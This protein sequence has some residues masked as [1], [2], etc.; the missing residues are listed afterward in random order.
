MKETD[1][2]LFASLPPTRLFFRCALPSMVSM[3]VSSLY[4][5]ADGIF[6][7]QFIGPEALAAV[8]L[9]MPIIMMGFSL[10]N[11]VAVGSSVQISI[12]LGE[13][14]RREA[15]S[16]F[17]VASLLILAISAV[18]GALGLFFAPNIL[19][20]MGADPTL[21]GL[22]AEYLRVF[23]AFSPAVMI[24]FAVDNY[25]RICGK[26][27]Y[28]MNMNIVTSVLNI[29]L[30]ALFLGV[31]RLGVGWAAFASCLS[32]TV[33]TVMGFWPFLRG[34]LALRFAKGKVPAKAIGNMLANGSS[35]FF[36]GIASSVAMVILNTALLR[37]AGSM[38]VAA[39]S[40]VMYV[41]SIVKSLLYG[42]V[43]AL[44]PAVS[45]NYGA[46]EN[47][48]VLALEGRLCLAGALISLVVLAAMQLGGGG[49][50]GLFTQSADSALLTMSVRA[51]Q[52][53]SLS[54]LV[55]WFGMLCSAFFT[56]L[57]RPVFSLT[58][59]FCQTLAFPL[60]FLN[61]LPRF[62][63]LDGIWAT[64]PASEFV[65]AILAGALLWRQLLKL[66]AA[67]KKAPTE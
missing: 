32:L 52:L 15:D 6:V 23:S 43:D 18:V 3:A 21:T 39:F 28:S 2:S 64:M 13:G 65:V 14:K 44:Q 45:Y 62:W 24:F 25:L 33:G 41:D 22:A 60:F 16:I 31:F 63:G 4:T 66:K 49:L 61:L 53:F 9:V 19:H 11:M 42:M 57:N 35:E 56:A 48:R 12:R 26:V 36:T 55:S 59:S 17:T 58:L 5:V 40:I 8:N 67:P 54:Y 50:I 1:T 46:G 27:R 34:K 37:T 20:L 47:R 38:A 51:M 29:I 7:G 10:A 30:D